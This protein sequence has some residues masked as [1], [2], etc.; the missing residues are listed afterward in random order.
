[1]PLKIFL[2]LCSLCFLFSCE[3]I[4]ADP[5][6]VSFEE[7]LASW[8]SGLGSESEMGS[9]DLV[10]DTKISGTFYESFDL[11]L[12]F[13]T[14]PISAEYELGGF[15][16]KL[17]KSKVVFDFFDLKGTFV[18]RVNF[19]VSGETDWSAWMN[20]VSGEGVSYI[21][22][23]KNDFPLKEFKPF[24]IANI[25]KE[26]NEGAERINAKKAWQD[27]KYPA[28]SLKREGVSRVRT[29][30]YAWSSGAKVKVTH[31]G[32]RKYL[33]PRSRPRVIRVSEP[34]AR[35]LPKDKQAYLEIQADRI[36]TKTFVAQ[37]V[38]VNPGKSYFVMVHARGDVAA[39]RP[40]LEVVDVSSG[41][42]LFVSE[43]SGSLAQA[44]W[45]PLGGVFKSEAELVS[46]RLVGRHFEF[47]TDEGSL[48]K[49]SYFFDD[50]QVQEVQEKPGKELNVVV[51]ERFGVKM[52]R[53]QIVSTHSKVDSVQGPNKKLGQRKI[54]PVFISNNTSEGE[55]VDAEEFLSDW[56]CSE[57]GIGGISLEEGHE[58]SKA[59]M[60]SVKPSLSESMKCTTVLPVPEY[61][62]KKSG[63]ISVHAWVWSDSPMGAFLEIESDLGRKALSG[64]HPG[65]GRWEHLTVVYPFSEII[66]ELT[67]TVHAEKGDAKFDNITPL[68]MDDDRFEGLPDHPFRFREKI[69]YEKSDRIRIVVLGNS[70]IFGTGIPRNA[71]FSY[72]LQS[73]LEALH[74]GKFEVINYGI[75]GWSL[76]P[77]LV[78][79][80]NHFFLGRGLQKD[81]HHFMFSNKIPRYLEDDE[82]EYL[83]MQN[84]ALSVKA[85]NPDILVAASLWNDSFIF[86]ANLL[87]NDLGEIDGKPSYLPYYRKVM[88]FLEQPS[89]KTYQSVNDVYQRAVVSGEESIKNGTSKCLD[90]E[91]LIITDDV[92]EFSRG[93][94]ELM[95][96]E[97]IRKSKSWT[98][99]WLATF[100]DR[101]AMEI[102][103]DSEYLEGRAKAFPKWLTGDRPDLRTMV[104]NFQDWT[105]EKLSKKHNAPFV[106]L[107]KK[108]FQEFKDIPMQDKIPV[109]RSYF[110]DDIHFS[111]RG[112]QFLADRFYSMMKTR[113]VDFKPEKHGD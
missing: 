42:K 57:S 112:N 83:M 24:T 81:M 3:K 10:L 58:S 5:K 97:F 40:M 82:Q 50:L 55:A 37:D 16:G 49:W 23:N 7:G 52:S 41:K 110:T 71:T 64:F 38:R 104:G 98:E 107:R 20:V 48:K 9:D 14:Q 111:P 75:D 79:L 70:T 108:Y 46:V 45:I 66:K 4:S 35:I 56:E 8:R 25:L 76:R 84:N 63:N 53:N 18:S 91:N 27:P 65:N 43:A 94:W 67:I 15:S 89:E 29:T 93:F 72:V 11:N 88:Q 44:G 22:I 36:F 26:Q 90:Y 33:L 101:L 61:A 102:Y 60:L 62:Q 95:M 74:P 28:V 47:K 96:S 12:D 51:E 73:K 103:D 1:M 21:T 106:N 78:S 86:C 19:L 92:K 30:F 80:E 77:Q 59:L 69:T 113:L 105:D 109:A 32:W 17:Y 85:L 68:I 13:L 31:R 34:R 54:R 87:T 99:V 100:P 6:N 2:T 39:L